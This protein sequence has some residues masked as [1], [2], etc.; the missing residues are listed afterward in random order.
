MAEKSRGPTGSFFAASE[1]NYPSL[2]P[3][4]FSMPVT[5][6][7]LTKKRLCWKSEKITAKI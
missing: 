5:I 4:S 3:L 6:S 1:D 7:A 2:W